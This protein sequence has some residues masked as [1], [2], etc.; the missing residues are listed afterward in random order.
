[1]EPWYETAAETVGRFTAEHAATLI[2]AGVTGAAGVLSGLFLRRRKKPPQSA[3]HIPVIPG[4]DVEFST[5]T[6]SPGDWIA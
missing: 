4:V 2:A 1:M 6:R 5:K 3:A